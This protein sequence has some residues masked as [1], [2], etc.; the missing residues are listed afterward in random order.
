MGCPNCA[1]R[2]HNALVSLDGVAGAH[3]RLD[4]PIATVR[5][6]RERL[7]EA[8]LIAAVARAGAGTHHMYRAR[9][10]L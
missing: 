3:V 6:E 4:P 2:V 7:T 1:N 10:L 5:Y 8:D 9:V